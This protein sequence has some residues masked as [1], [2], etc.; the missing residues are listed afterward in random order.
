MACEDEGER[1]RFSSPTGRIKMKFWICVLAVAVAVKS[2]H[3]VSPICLLLAICSV[4][5]KHRLNP[6]VCLFI[7]CLYFRRTPRSDMTCF[8][9]YACVEIVHSTQHNKLRTNFARTVTKATVGLWIICVFRKVTKFLSSATR[10]AALT[11]GTVSCVLRDRGVC[12]RSLRGLYCVGV[13]SVCSPKLL[14]YP[15]IRLML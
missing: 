15:H 13:K 6:C 10:L 5:L 1:Q 12:A 14:T 11:F 2:T 7:R 8:T 4:V 3:G 9:L